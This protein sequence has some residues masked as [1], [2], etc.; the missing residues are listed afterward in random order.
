[1][2]KSN[3]VYSK[4]LSGNTYTFLELIKREKGINVLKRTKTIYNLN[5]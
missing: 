5:K 4:C 1:M 3:K 2:D